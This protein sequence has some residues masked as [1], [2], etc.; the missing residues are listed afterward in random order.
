M[1]LKDLILAQCSKRDLH[2]S[3]AVAVVSPSR[4]RFVNFLNSGKDGPFMN[5]NMCLFSATS[6][7]IHLFLDF[8]LNS[9]VMVGQLVG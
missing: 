8:G 2:C 5:Y 4:F 7:A 6:K 3:A 9:A 1:V